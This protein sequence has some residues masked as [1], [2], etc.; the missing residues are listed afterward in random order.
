MQQLGAVPSN[1]SGTL[2]KTNYLQFSAHISFI[3]IIFGTYL[4]PIYDLFVTN[5]LYICYKIDMQA[6]GAPSNG[7]ETLGKTQL[8]DTQPFEQQRREQ[9]TI[10]QFDL[11][12]ISY[13][14]FLICTAVFCAVK[15]L[16][17]IC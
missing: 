6:R 16:S 10:L 4:L 11:K 8:S 2:G 1:A 15:D 7:S 12:I 5:L 14:E 9:S 13:R 17:H 3:F